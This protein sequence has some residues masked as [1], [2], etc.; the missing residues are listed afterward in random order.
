VIQMTRY[1]LLV[2]GLVFLLLLP[3]SGAAR[4]DS[5]P[6][7]LTSAREG[8]FVAGEVLL[9]FKPGV[10]AQARAGVLRAEGASVEEILPVPGLRRVSVPRQRSVAAAVAALERRPEILFA[11]P[12]LLHKLSP[13]NYANNTDS[14]L[15]MLA[16]MSLAGRTG[17]A[18]DYD[19]RLD[20]E[21][22]YDYFWVE[23]ATSAAGPWAIINGWTGSTDGDFLPFHEDL[24]DADGQPSVFL[25]LRLTSDELVTDDGAY[26]D[27]LAV[28]C[29]SSTFDATSFR[30]ESG[31]SM[32][33]PHVAG[34]A[35]L[36]WAQTPLASVSTV[37]SAL[38]AGVDP[39]PSLFGKVS[40]GGR[41]NA[42]KT[43]VSSCPSPSPVLPNDPRFA[44]L[45]GLSQPSDADIDAPEAW[46]VESGDP[47]VVVAVVDTGVAYDHPELDGN[48]WA[49]T[50]DPP[51]GGDQ[52][53]NGFVDDFRGWDFV[54][55]DNDPRDLD[56]HG[57]H[58]AGTIGAEGNNSAGIA[59]VN[60]DVSLM[61]LRAGDSSGL[62]SSDIVAS[63]VYACREGAH[64]VNG[65]FG[66]YS[67]SGS[68]LAALQ[69]AE[70]ANTLFVF[71]AGNDA[72]SNDDFPV[73]PC[74]H[75]APF[76]EADLPNIVCVAATNK[77]DG[78]AEFSNYGFGSVDLAAPGVD[79][80]STFPAYSTVATDDF[81][82]DLPGRW[83]ATGLAGNRIWGRTTEAS[84]GG[85][86]SVADSPTL[87]PSP[88]VLPPAPLPDTTPPSNPR[89][90]SSSHPVGVP[91][92]DSII[93]V[94]W[95][96]ALDAQSGVDGFSFTL[97]TSP[98]TVP[99]A[100]K[101]AEE[102]VGGATFSG[103]ANGSY[104][105][106][107][108]T[109]DNAGNWTSTV[110]YGPLIVAVPRIVSSV[111]CVVPNIKGKTVAAARKALVARKCA[112][113][114]VRRKY[115]SK[116][117]NRIVAQSRR[118]GARLPRGTK[119]NV[120]VSRGRRR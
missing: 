3:G 116:A 98:A 41:L 101:D 107:L 73:Y 111:R 30:R 104:V 86:F 15:A 82:T 19:M 22:F 112:L 76:P 1:S 43:L 63:F 94:A 39:K 42:C 88:P 65:S 29:L 13:D 7:R 113:G 102:T 58:V 49:N 83:V 32:A 27:N 77:L 117:K 70:C 47:G 61:P 118:P 54:D 44:D 110:H 31:T 89:V 81:E 38:L 109:R 64:V 46:G 72:S 78:L 28:K 96:G 48:V 103:L 21:Y 34:V 59:G 25:R 45:W 4:L 6:V 36:K 23:R 8:A 105:F 67:P 24:S 120:T 119:V 20:T 9:R 12:N 68:V 2:S 60:W 57:T 90:S 84:A 114:K 26:V 93:D 10:S 69:S 50:A 66:G 62:S 115:S 33:A 51:G 74:N 18:V 37:K 80:L 35:A 5:G 95:S 97:D 75:G 14:T 56:G 71:S 53:G 16:P 52:D 17:C 85:S 87:P 91:T 106:H 55:D 40:S 99:D 79:I 100:L 108:R 92:N 11:E